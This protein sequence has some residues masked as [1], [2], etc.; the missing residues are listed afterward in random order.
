MNTSDFIFN[1]DHCHL[2]RILDDAAIDRCVR[3]VVQGDYWGLLSASV[4]TRH[5]RLTPGRQR[6]YWSTPEG[7]HLLFYWW[8]SKEKTLR[9]WIL[10]NIRVFTSMTE[11]TGRLTQKSWTR[12][13]R[14]DFDYWEDWGLS[15]FAGL[16]QI[17]FRWCWEGNALTGIW[18]WSIDWC[19]DPVP[20]WDVLYSLWPW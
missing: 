19:R 2:Q 15:W 10:V 17:L 5:S 9:K 11:W 6:K 12:R 8:T 4:R 14:V 1:S 7:N 16:C 3:D 13:T 20:L 18:R